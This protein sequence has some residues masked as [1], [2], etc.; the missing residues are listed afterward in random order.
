[1]RMVY[2]HFPVNCA[3]ADDKKSVEIRNFLGEKIVRRVNLLEG[4]TMTRSDDVK[5]EIVLVGNDVENVG[6]SGKRKRY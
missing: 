3:I 6:Q 5:D 4:V 2:A 1:M